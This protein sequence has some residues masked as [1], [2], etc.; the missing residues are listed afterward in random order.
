MTTYL[1]KREMTQ[2][3]RTTAK[4]KLRDTANPESLL[5]EIL[6]RNPRASLQHIRRAHPIFRGM[7]LDHLGVRIGQIIDSRDPASQK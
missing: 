7:S 3:R 5:R 4:V 6:V 1:A 2:L